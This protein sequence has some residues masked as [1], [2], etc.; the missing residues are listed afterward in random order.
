MRFELDAIKRINQVSHGSTHIF[1]VKF[2]KFYYGKLVEE[3]D[4]EHFPSV[5]PSRLGDSLGM[6]VGKLPLS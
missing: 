1:S 4:Q 5:S 6:E 3:D 2:Y